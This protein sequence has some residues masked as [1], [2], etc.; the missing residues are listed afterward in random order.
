MKKIFSLA[1]VM[2]LLQA[3][4]LNLVKI[5][6]DGMPTDIVVKPI[7]IQANVVPLV[8]QPVKS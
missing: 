5:D 8:P 2:L 6:T 1:P 4:S 7:S 3:C